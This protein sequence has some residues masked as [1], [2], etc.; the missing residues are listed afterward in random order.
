[1]GLIDGTH[2]R[3]QRPSEIEAVC[4]NQHFTTQLTSKLF[5]NRMERSVMFWHVSLGLYTIKAFGRC[6]VL[7]N[8][9]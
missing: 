3:I 7:W 8:Y 6:R 9:V 4:I 1:M 2:I 5:A